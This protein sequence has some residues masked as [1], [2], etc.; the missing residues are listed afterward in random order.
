RY[1]DA[2]LGGQFEFMDL[3][4]Q[5]PHI[6]ALVLG[7]NNFQELSRRSPQTNL[8]IDPN[9]KQSYIDQFLIGL[10]RE[11]IPNFSATVQVIR[12]NFKNFMGFVDTGSIY[13]PITKTDPG[14]DGKLGTADDAG[15]VTV[16]NKTNPGHE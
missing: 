4:N 3:T 16:F 12:R 9:I 7:P 1:A 5:N 15:A 14:P 6:T 8:G 2:L 11:L 10:E 13:A